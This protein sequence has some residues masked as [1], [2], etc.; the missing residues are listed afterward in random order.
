MEHDGSS[1]QQSV[2]WGPFSG[3]LDVEGNSTNPRS[4]LHNLVLDSWGWVI[5][6]SYYLATLKLRDV[7]FKSKKSP[8]SRCEGQ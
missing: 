1:L 8:V 6:Y 5:Y 3:G 4:E 2:K 7:V